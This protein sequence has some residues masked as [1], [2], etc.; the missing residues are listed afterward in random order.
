MDVEADSACGFEC[1]LQLHGVLTAF[2]L[3]DDTP[4]DADYIGDIL[5]GEVQLAAA[6]AYRGAEVGGCHYPV[7][8]IDR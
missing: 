6:A 4:V 3:T 5:L 7:H 2:E 8:V 1:D